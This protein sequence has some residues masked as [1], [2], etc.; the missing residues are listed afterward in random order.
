MEISVIGTGYVGLV[1]GVCFADAGHKVICVDKDESKIN[2]LLEGEVPIYEPGLEDI[3]KTAKSRLTFTTDIK[4]AVETTDIIFIAVGTPEKED[5]SADLGP[6]QK[7][8]DSICEYANRKKYIVLKSTVPVGTA[9]LLSDYCANKGKYELTLINNPEFLKEGAAIDDFL[10]PDRVVIGTEDEK[11]RELMRDL[12][13]P[14]VKNGNPILFMGNTSAEM[15]KYA[16]NAFLSVKIS[17]V[18]ELARLADAVGADIDE[19]RKG[20]TSDNRINPAFFYPGVGFGGSCFPK[21]VKALVFTG[22]QNDVDM[23]VVEASDIVND[24][25]KTLL[26]QRAK[27]YF[28]D[29]SGKTIALWGLSF[30]P[31]TDDVREAP[32]LYIIKELVEAG[33]KVT[34]YDPVARETALAAT[35]KPFELCDSAEA[36]C[37]GA[38][39]LM[40]V[41]EW[42][43]FKSPNF[44]LIKEKLNEPVVFDGRNVYNPKK[45]IKRGF[46][47]FCIGRQYLAN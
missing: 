30:K 41:T 1:A 14:F 42:N 31:R 26:F 6:T 7:V 11:A 18:N 38:D 35:F 5:G 46:K 2:K 36:A 16:A 27:N 13:A 4:M 34:A 25:Q 3:I 28:G 19:V 47:Y 44:D 24:E 12:Y 9:K 39:A 8:I 29:L 21:D 20:F 22:Q 23:K 15:T 10:K 43:E 37:E 32:A 17:F 40:L 33:A 45:M